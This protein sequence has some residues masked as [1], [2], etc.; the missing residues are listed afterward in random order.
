MRAAE[1]Q[2]Y[3]GVSPRTLGYWRDAGKP[4]RP[5]RLNGSYHYPIAAVAE[6]LSAETGKEQ[7]TMLDA[8]AQ[9]RKAHGT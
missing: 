6:F 3:L 9:P 8:P 7:Q 5:K 1:L 4:P 2:R